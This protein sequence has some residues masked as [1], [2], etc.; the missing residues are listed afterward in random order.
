[1]KL[2]LRKDSRDLHFQEHFGSTQVIPTELELD[3]GLTNPIEG[4]QEVDCTAI[5][6]CD[7]A[8]NQTGIIY[9]IHE[10]WGQVPQTSE[11]ADPRDT[12]GVMISKGLK[13]EG[14]DTA[15]DTR[16]S[17]YFRSDT[18]SQTPFLNTQSAM[19]ISQSPTTVGSNWYAEWDSVQPDSIMPAGLTRVSGHDYE[20]TGWKNNMFHIKAWLGYSMWMPDVV[21]N[22]EL[23]RLGCVAFI[24][25]TNQIDA[26]R[27]K[28][29]IEMLID[30]MTNL[31]LLLREQLSTL[32]TS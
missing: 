12:L 15:R 18:G 26:M 28:T 6:A 22:T 21:F 1:M 11:G 4:A 9:D 17:S 20:I 27:K 19:Y 2:K 3:K 5:S 10:L 13:P 31:V 16:W 24:P 32:S 7:V 23:N 29:L 14:L 25:S 30:A 8:T